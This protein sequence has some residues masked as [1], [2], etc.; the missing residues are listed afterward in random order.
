MKKII[1]SL[2][3][4]SLFF[5]ST[6]SGEEKSYLKTKDAI[7]ENIKKYFDSS[8]D[9][10]PSKFAETF[11]SDDVEVQINDV[12]IKGKENYI[13][14]LKMIHQELIK[15]MKFEKL[16]IHTNYFSN[17]AI[18]WDGKTFGE[19][20]PNEKTIWTNAW[21]TLTGTG[22]VTKKKISF[23]I[24]M[25][26]RTSKGKVVQMLAFYDPSQMNEEIKALE[27]SK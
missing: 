25:D 16:H 23:N 3:S 21:A 15:D 17:E 11:Y 19:I 27:A 14:R 13:K 8:S 5:A 12:I 26:F 2:L 7:S 1:S 10:Q 4:I 6:L 20:R 9:E 22:R 18:A 24:H